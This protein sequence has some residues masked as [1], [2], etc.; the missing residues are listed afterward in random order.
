MP[1]ERLIYMV[2]HEQI[3]EPKEWN[4]IINIENLEEKQNR[5]KVIQEE[6][7]SLKTKK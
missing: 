6:I 5:I 3:R 1:P 2:K 7:E 4:D